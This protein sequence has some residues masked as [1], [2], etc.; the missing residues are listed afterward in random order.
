MVYSAAS[1]SGPIKITAAIVAERAA[2]FCLETVDLTSPQA[3][4]VLLSDSRPRAFIPRLVDLFMAGRFPIDPLIA[5]CEFGD[6][7]RAAADAGSG[8]TIK[9]LLRLAS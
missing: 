7:N 3:D 1:G 5:R 6:I 2:P 4:E 9:P 8:V